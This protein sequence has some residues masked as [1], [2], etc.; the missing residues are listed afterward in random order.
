MP[1]CL[2]KECLH[3]DLQDLRMYKMDYELGIN[4]IKKNPA[5]PIILKNPDS[6]NYTL[7]ALEGL[8]K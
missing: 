8:L 7:K 3:Q 2:N 4:T 1:N 5:N 6:H